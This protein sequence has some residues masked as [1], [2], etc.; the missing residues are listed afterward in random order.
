MKNILKRRPGLN[1]W[2]MR[3][4]H[5]KFPVMK[6]R[7]SVSFWDSW[8]ETN[9]PCNQPNTG[10]LY[11]LPLYDTESLLYRS[12]WYKGVTKY[13]TIS[14]ILAHVLNSDGWAY[15]V[16]RDAETCLR[17]TL[18]GPTILWTLQMTCLL[19]WKKIPKVNSSRVLESLFPF[20]KG[21]QITPFQSYT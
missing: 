9:F 14:T 17:F 6:Y 7:S 21:L 20:S 5:V 16:L 11:I 13:T 1:Q 18:P 10:W 8:L 3:Y 2:L 12:S 15:L 19:N 4:K